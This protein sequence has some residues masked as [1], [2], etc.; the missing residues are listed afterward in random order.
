[1]LFALNGVSKVET[2][3]IVT[4]LSESFRM[5]NSKEIAKHF[6]SSVSLSLLNNENVYSSAQSE[7]I[8]DSFFRSNP[9]QQSKVLHHLDNNANHQH[10]VLLLTTSSGNFR[11]ALSLKKNNNLLQLIEIRIDQSN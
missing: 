8:L 5:G 2:L 7:I 4:E 11:V 1:M 10:A 9:P 3:D 6:S